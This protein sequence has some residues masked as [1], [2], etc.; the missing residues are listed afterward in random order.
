[1]ISHSD[2]LDILSEIEVHT[3]KVLRAE[4]ID[5]AICY[6]R[7]RVDWLQAGSGA[8]P[9]LGAIR[10][11]AHNAF[12]ESLNALSRH[13]TA[14]GCSTQWRDRLGQDRKQI[15]DFACH[16]HTILGLRAR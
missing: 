4:M 3:D 13:A 15:G 14:S 5:C 6:A 10:T 8:D 9:V 11:R 16:L 2:A 1:M 7:L 12:I